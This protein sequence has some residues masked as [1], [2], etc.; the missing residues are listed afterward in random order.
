MEVELGKVQR[1]LLDSESVTTLKNVVLSELRS[2]GAVLHRTGEDRTDVPID[3]RLRDALLRAAE[4][5]P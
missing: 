3:H 5:Q 4:I 2:R 1:C